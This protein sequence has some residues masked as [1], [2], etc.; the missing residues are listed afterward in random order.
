[1]KAHA[2]ASLLLVASALAAPLVHVG[3]ARAD[4]P[5]QAAKALF[6]AGA[7]A[8]DAGQFPAAIQAFEQAYRLAARPGIL[9]S[10]AQ[11]HR[12]QF[13]IAKNPDDLR[14]A[15]K[16]YRDYLAQVQQGGRRSDA[17]EALAELEPIAGKLDVGSAAA[18]P[19]QQASATRL[20]VSS[21]TPGAQ[22]MVDGGKALDVPLIAEVKAG[23]HSLHVTAKG[24]F[25]ETRDID[26]AAGSVAALDL[27]LRDKPGHLSIRSR[28]GA[29]VTIDGRLAAETPLSQ[30][31]DVEPGRHLVVIGKNGF[32]PW[33]QEI[34]VGPDEARQLDAPLG[35]TGQRAASYV[36]IGAGVAAA[37]V[38]GV[39]VGLS[40]H[41]QSQAQSFNA[42]RTAG[43][44]SC[45]TSQACS[46]LTNT[47]QGQVTARD[48]YNIGAGAAFAAAV[49]VGGTGI[50]LFAFDQPNMNAVGGHRDEGPKPAAPARDRPME[51]SAAPLLGPGLYGATLVGRF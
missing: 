10:I 41:S 42:M 23:K 35:G 14:A 39:F 47:Y 31:I 48:D 1:M 44:V 17:A 27:P 40:V 34:D 19:S 5:D 11:A 30:P 51:L 3:A 2:A 6:Y 45:A 36:L 50:V 46:N 15:L 49:L 16:G 43:T 4:T 37:I 21:P 9:F 25:D 8:Y 13:Y 12:K 24:H 29:Q 26:V 28:A 38:G 20:M 33:S 32:K 18:T 22:V 7:Q